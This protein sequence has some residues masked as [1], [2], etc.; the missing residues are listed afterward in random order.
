M[1]QTRELIDALKRELRAQ[2]L[3]Y[4]DVAKELELS[5]ASVK[6]MFSE[7]SFTLDRLTK[8]C[9]L[10]GWDFVDLAKSLQSNRSST[11]SLTLEQEKD[12]A[13]NL[14]LLLVT[15]SVINGFSYEQLL[16]Y[17]EFSE[18]ECIQLLAKLDRLKLIELLPRNRI[19]LRI[20]SNFR[21]NPEGPIQSF[22]LERVVE[23]FF[24][25]RFAK[26]NEK[27]VVL[28][29]LLTAEGNAHIQ[30][31]LDRLAAEFSTINSDGK[32]VAMDK[33]EG[34]T[35]VLALRQWRFPLFDPHLKK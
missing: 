33:K 5:H 3:T 27:L 31:K 6:R 14:S 10:L 21:W 26:Y 8:V 35:L 13:A 20:S 34:N 29:G 22:F 18:H 16:E 24:D 32:S 15:V 17:Y 11:E 7:S 25:T 19:R 30:E 2:K 12:I 23:Q 9:E 1:A 4:V 28:N